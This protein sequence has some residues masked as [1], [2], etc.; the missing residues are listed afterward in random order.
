MVGAVKMLQNDSYPRYSFK[1]ELMNSA[2]RLD[3]RYETKK[4]IGVTSGCLV[5]APV[6]MKLPLTETGEMEGKAG[7]EEEN[8]ESGS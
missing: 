4:R 2:E 8:Q 1:A 6:I 3:V 5:W 7:L